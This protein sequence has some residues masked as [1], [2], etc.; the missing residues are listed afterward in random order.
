MSPQYTNELTPEILASID[1]SPF[2]DEHLAGMSEEARIVIEEQRAFWQQHPVTA[3]YR[4]AVVGSQT[5]NGGTVRM[6]SSGLEIQLSDGQTARVANTGD[7][8]DYPDGTKAEIVTGTGQTLKAKEEGP[9]VALVGSLLSNGDEII[10]TP[11]EQAWIV[12]RLGVPLAADFL[13]ATADH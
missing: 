6:A 13:C 10:S 7:Y 2:T 12:Q 9:S 1:N 8:V 5:R 3:I 4:L 11:Q